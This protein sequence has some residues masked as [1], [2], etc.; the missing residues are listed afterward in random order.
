MIEQQYIDLF[1]QSR[2]DL[3]GH[4]SQGMNVHREAAFETFKQIGFPTS[5][6]EDYK[7]SNIARAFDAKL[8][9][10]LRNVPVEVDPYGARATCPIWL[11]TFT[12]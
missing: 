12:S 6:L 1:Q 2:S 4:S 7:H 9:L 3:D 8:G 11:L 5:K 10:N